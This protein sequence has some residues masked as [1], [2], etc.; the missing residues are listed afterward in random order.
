MF[1]YS[2]VICSKSTL[3]VLLNRALF[4]VFPGS[5]SLLRIGDWFEWVKM[6][7]EAVK[8]RFTGVKWV[9]GRCEWVVG[10]V[11]VGFWVEFLLEGGFFG[12]E[13]VLVYLQRPL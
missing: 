2:S 4:A 5:S 13:W 9:V 6:R 8:W 11:E 3:A 10:G 1:E 7:L 12:L